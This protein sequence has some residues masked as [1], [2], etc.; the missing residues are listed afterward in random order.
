MRSITKERRA[1]LDGVLVG[2]NRLTWPLLCLG[3][4]TLCLRRWG[5][6]D[7]I[8]VSPLSMVIFVRRRLVL[9]GSRVNGRFVLSRLQFLS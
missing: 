6:L 9:S 7:V 8:M 1:S 3:F 2:L 5:W 4:R